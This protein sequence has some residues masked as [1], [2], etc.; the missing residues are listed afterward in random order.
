MPKGFLMEGQLVKVVCSRSLS[1][2]LTKH[3]VWISFR[4]SGATF[5]FHSRISISNLNT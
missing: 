1:P 4:G 3:R 2:L 5:C